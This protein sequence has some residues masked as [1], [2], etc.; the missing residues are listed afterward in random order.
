[1]ANEGFAEPWIKFEQELGLRPNLYGPKVAD[2]FAGW[3]KLGGALVSKYTFPAPDVS[4]ATEDRTIGDGIKVRIYTPSGYAKGSKPVG[5]YI[6]GGGWAMGD[7]DMDDAGCR[8][9]SKGA[10]VVLVSVDYRLAPQHPY[11]AGPDDCVTAYKWILENAESLGGVAGK[12]FIGGAS[13]GGNLVFTTALRIIDE[14]LG[15]SI[16]GLAAQVPV[17]IHPDLV[18]ADLKSK[19]TSYVEHA[20]HTV[21]TSSAMRAFFDAYGNPTDAYANPLL[22]DKLSQLPKVYM[23]V[24]GHDTLRDDGRLMKEKLES[25]G[26]QV[27]YDEYAG[28]PHYFWTFPAE[29]LKEPAA[30]YNANLVKG[31]EFILS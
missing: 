22:S 28:Y 10:S 3:E 19:Y 6:H 26:V 23:T 24:A 14:G 18:P 31:I 29:V 1:M 17:T 21:N 2:C 15:S 20:E 13:A 27:K 9:M 8:V 12:V 25:N 11:P 5:M 30:E 4:V 16:V 7:L